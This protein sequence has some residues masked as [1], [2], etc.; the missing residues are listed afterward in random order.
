MDYCKY[1]TD[2]LKVQGLYYWKCKVSN[3]KDSWGHCDPQRR[4]VYVS[5]YLLSHGTHEEIIQTI[6]HEVAHAL[7]PDDK[8]H[9][10]DW[11]AKARDLG[12]TGGRCADRVLPIKHKYIGHCPVGHKF[13]MHRKTFMHE[14]YCYGCDR[15]LELDDRM[16]LWYDRNNKEDVKLF[17]SRFGGTVFEEFEHDL[18]SVLALATT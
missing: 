4:T 12:Y 16:I 10:A 15:E 17:I 14:K 13:V 1:G 9:G 5:K 2:L 6:L 3:T 7:T 8:G 18:D 11:L